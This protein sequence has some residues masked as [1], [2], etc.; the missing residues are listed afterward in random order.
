M[1]SRYANC[2]SL[3]SRGVTK[4]NVI[5]SATR[6]NELALHPKVLLLDEP[7]ASLGT[8]TREQ[9]HD[10]LIGLRKAIGMRMLFVTHDVDEELKLADNSLVM[11]RNGQG[12]IESFPIAEAR[13]RDIT[14]SIFIGLRRCIR[15]LLRL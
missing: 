5:I 13:P 14:E 3:S 15:H 7:F 11:G 4:I 12:I 1:N 9:T 8:I 10:L 6:K 2:D